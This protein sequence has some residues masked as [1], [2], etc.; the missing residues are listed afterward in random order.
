[1][2][3]NRNA[4]STKPQGNTQRR[5]A[6]YQQLFTVET[7]NE[8]KQNDFLEKL[9]TRLTEDEAN[10]ID[11]EVTAVEQKRLKTP[12]FADDTTL[13][14]TGIDSV[15][16]TFA[17]LENFSAAS[18]LQLNRA[19]TKGIALGKLTESNPGEPIKQ[20]NA[21]KTLD[22]FNITFGHGN[23]TR[24]NWIKA[25]AKITEKLK[26]LSKQKTTLIGKSILIKATV[27]PRIT[28]VAKTFLIP[29]AI[30]REIN[31]RILRYAMT[32]T[33]TRLTIEQIAKKDLDGGMD[34]TDIGTMAEM[35]FTYALRPVADL[36]G[37]IRLW[38]RQYARN[39]ITDD[40]L[41]TYLKG[42][43]YNIGKTLSARMKTTMR[44][45]IPHRA[46][47]IC[48]YKD[49]LLTIDKYKLKAED[50][51]KPTKHH[52]DVCVRERA[53]A[54]VHPTLPLSHGTMWENSLNNILPNH[55]TEFNYKLI[56]NHLALGS[57]RGVSSSLEQT[58]K[59][60]LCK[61]ELETVEHLFAKCKEI[62][63]A[64]AF[65]FV[66]IQ[67]LTTIT[68]LNTRPRLCIY[69]DTDTPNLRDRPNENTRHNITVIT[70]TL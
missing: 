26:Q 13:T 9:E 7:T 28:A 2:D 66:T 43:E 1:M 21:N 38:L 22:I 65:A 29:T 16:R 6:F 68:L 58:R 57:N 5:D 12:S 67:R 34:I 69:L 70:L 47:A 50:Y 31:K 46:I 17:T 40:A 32:K 36:E 33:P 20:W 60:P 61:T 24:I 55:I 14:L 37:G 51:V 3:T 64:W 42:I 44:N 35:L 39:R 10:L 45:D 62:R 8:T 15:N 25:K 41:P 54:T 11:S 23:I 27:M 53:G 30:R 19:K 4:F 18:G 56:W 52:Y 48:Y 63:M 49:T 59:C